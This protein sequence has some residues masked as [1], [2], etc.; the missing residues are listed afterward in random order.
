MVIKMQQT[1]KRL[2]QQKWRQ[3]VKELKYT[4]KKW[5]KEYILNKNKINIHF[6]WHFIRRI[7]PG[8]QKGKTVE[9]SP[10]S[11]NIILSLRIRIFPLFYLL[12]FP[13][14]L[15]FFLFISSV[16]LLMEFF[17][18]FLRKGGKWKELAH[19]LPPVDLGWPHS[20]LLACSFLVDE[21]T[22]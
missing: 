1:R 17:N 19:V 22:S 8:A 18:F 14:I 16:P 13:L 4:S 10:I 6:I 5:F 2:R 12:Y 11:Y 15:F 21:R 20:W 9:F 3:K 7:S